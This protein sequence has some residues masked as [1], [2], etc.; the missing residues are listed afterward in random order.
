MA[1]NELSDLAPKPDAPVPGAP[2]PPAGHKVIARRAG[3][4]LTIAGVLLLETG[5][6]GV[7]LFIIG[8]LSL[9]FS[10]FFDRFIGPKK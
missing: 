3:I 1:D 4:G 2:K 10:G 6:F 5:P 9:I 8:L 7:G